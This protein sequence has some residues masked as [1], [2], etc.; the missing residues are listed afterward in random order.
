MILFHKER[1]NINI[2]IKHIILVQAESLGII[3]ILTPSH[4][5]YNDVS[6]DIEK[7]KA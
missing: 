4:S 5:K 3:P 6:K 2:V 1:L 7:Y